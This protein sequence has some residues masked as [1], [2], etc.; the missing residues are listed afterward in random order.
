MWNVYY[1]LRAVLNGKPHFSSR[2]VSC[3]AGIVFADL[4]AHTY[5][6]VLP[7]YISVSAVCVMYWPLDGPEA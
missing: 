1:W 5:V 3:T 4:F 2:D 7:G 6:L